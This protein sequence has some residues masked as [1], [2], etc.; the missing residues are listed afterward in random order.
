M[1]RLGAFG[2]IRIALLSICPCSGLGPTLRLISNDMMTMAWRQ[3]VL[4]KDH[5]LPE[6]AAGGKRCTACSELPNFLRSE[7]TD[8]VKDFHG[9]TESWKC[10]RDSVICSSSNSVSGLTRSSLGRPTSCY[11]AMPRR[12]HSQ[13]PPVYYLD[14][15]SRLTS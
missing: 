14:L 2:R 7:I 13:M 6:K 3:G 11:R 5:Q 12:G 8:S 4:G 10:F 9:S 1:L 15:V